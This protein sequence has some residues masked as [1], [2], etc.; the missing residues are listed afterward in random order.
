MKKMN[1]KV[2]IVII[3]IIETN[4]NQNKLGEIIEYQSLLP[5][6]QIGRETA[7]KGSS[8]TFDHVYLL[9][10]NCIKT[11]PNCEGSYIDSSSD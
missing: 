8:F 7:M 1:K 2:V 4:I 5:G 11:N 6:Y 10:H 9:P 3:I